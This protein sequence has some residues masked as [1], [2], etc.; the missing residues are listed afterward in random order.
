MEEQVKIR[1][2]IGLSLIA[3]LVL[4]GC[5][6]TT[7]T[8]REQVVTGKLPR[9]ETIWVYDFAATPADLPIKTSLDKEYFSG[10]E[11]QTP[12]QIAEGRKLGKEIE[13]ELVYLIRE[14]GINAEHAMAGTTQQVNDIVLQGYILSYNE[15]SEKER[16]VLGLGAGNSD[17]KVA[18]EGLQ[19]TANGLRLI[20]S[21]SMDAEGNK[22]PGGAVGLATL[23]ATHNPAGLIISTGMK[24]YDE[25][26]GAGKVEGRA[27]Q[28]AKEIADILKKRFEEQGWLK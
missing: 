21:G 3:L 20:G 26:S 23:I 28:T 1:Y 8:D 15:G 11:P 24:V 14:M 5:A 17:L 13:T 19:M 27:K 16:V 10:S 12:E 22:T 7:V 6:K 25:K 4:A 9:P 2:V 18:V